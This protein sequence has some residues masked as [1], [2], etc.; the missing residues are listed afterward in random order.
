MARSVVTKKGKAVQIEGLLELQERVADILDRTTGKAIKRVYMGAALVLRDEARDLAP[1]LKKPK[2]GRVPGLL[3]SAIRAAYGDPTKPNVL[4]FVDY[5]IA[6]HAHLVEF[7]TVKMQAQP[8]MRPAL[9]AARSKC[10]NIIAD[11]FR[12]LIEESSAGA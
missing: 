4:V 3:K 1:E 6:P 7:G 2:K 11:G 9:A 12:E 8:Y 10:V 5:R